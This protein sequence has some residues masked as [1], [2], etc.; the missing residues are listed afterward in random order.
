[1]NQCS[2]SCRG[3]LC[4]HV[5]LVWKGFDWS[6][7]DFM[8][9]LLTVEVNQSLLLSATTSWLKS[10][11]ASKSKLSELIEAKQSSWWKIFRRSSKRFWQKVRM[12]TPSGHPPPLSP[13]RLMSPTFNKYIYQFEQIQHTPPLHNHWVKQFLSSLPSEHW[14]FSKFVE[15]LKLSECEP[16]VICPLWIDASHPVL[17]SNKISIICSSIWRNVFINLDKYI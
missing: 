6:Y 11:K 1:M 12:P 15:L 7:C 14:P 13:F 3:Y 4:W 17:F 2:E 5:P 9:N 8:K 10:R 16:Y